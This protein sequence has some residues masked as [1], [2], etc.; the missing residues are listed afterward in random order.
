MGTLS[1]GQRGPLDQPGLENDPLQR[2]Q[3]EPPKSPD[4]ERA[5]GVK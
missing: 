2:A 1:I 5:P 4:L 3:A